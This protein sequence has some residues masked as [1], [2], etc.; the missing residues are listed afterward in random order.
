M[1]LDSIKP[2]IDSALSES[3]TLRAIGDDEAQIHVPFFFPDG[4]G[5]V[6]HVRAAGDRLELTDRANTLLNLSYHTDVARLRDDT[7][8]RLLERIQLRHGVQ[9]RDGELILASTEQTLG[10]SVF[11][12]VQALLEIS[13]LRN[14]DRETVRSAFR[15]DVATLLD[16]NFPAIHHGYVDR[17][18][19]PTGNYPIPYVLNGT[20]R[21]VAVFDVGTDNAA[22][23]AVI[24]ARQHRE[25][26]DNM[27]FVAVE[28]TQEDLQ[29][30]NVAW[31]SDAF[32][33]QFPRLHGCEDAVVTYLRREWALSQQLAQ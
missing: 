22:L 30:K 1:I 5:L 33:K 3:V 12:F 8:A 11:S 28:E 15:E 21:P 29:R 17:Q 25:W 18:H 6:V 20:Q 16:S 9:E 32:D 14:L 26:N 4:D 2:A 13:D 19:D 31:L 10:R 27:L 7:R 23:Q 24:V